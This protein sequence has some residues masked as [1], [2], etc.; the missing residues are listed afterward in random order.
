MLSPC[1][2]E[3]LSFSLA[4][5]CTRG[6]IRESILKLPEKWRMQ[7]PLQPW[8]P[9]SVQMWLYQQWAKQPWQKEWA[10]L[11]QLSTIMPSVPSSFSLT[12]SS[13]G[14][15][16][17]LILLHLSP[18]NLLSFDDKCNNG[19]LTFKVSLLQKEATT[20]HFLIPLENFP[21]WPNRVNINVSMHTQTHTNM[22][23]QFILWYSSLGCIHFFCYSFR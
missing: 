4:C 19:L 16:L 11:F 6:W 22:H 2:L 8:W 10:T 12:S 3:S 23:T 15:C 18:A 20:S 13:T 9:W 17:V 21:P 7:Y 5:Y 14:F 1:K